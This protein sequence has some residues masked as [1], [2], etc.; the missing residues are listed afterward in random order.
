MKKLCPLLSVAAF[1]LLLTSC[2]DSKVP[3]PR[4]TQGQ[5]GRPV[6]RSVAIPGRGR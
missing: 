5:T 2:F 1:S 3:R 6:D 4:P